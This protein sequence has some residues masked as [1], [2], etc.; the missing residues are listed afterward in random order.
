MLRPLLLQAR[1]IKLR[2]ALAI[3]DT[4]WFSTNSPYE[5]LELTR[6]LGHG[7]V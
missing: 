3:G 6:D 1:M 5:E 2:V 7:L 4:G